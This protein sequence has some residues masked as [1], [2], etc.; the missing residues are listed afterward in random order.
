M[1]KAIK[2]LSIIIGTYFLF[3]IGQAA[4]YAERGYNA[5]GGECLI[6]TFPIFYY[7]I[8][9]CVKDSIQMFKELDEEAAE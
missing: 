9:Q 2:I 4:A 6:L 7:I 3:K 1:K 5:F 8:R